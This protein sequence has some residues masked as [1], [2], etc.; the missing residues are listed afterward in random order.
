MWRESDVRPLVVVWAIVPRYSLLIDTYI[1]D[2]AERERL[3][4]A[5]ARVPAVRAKA[6]WA[7]RWIGSQVRVA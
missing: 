6:E 3:F 5:I 1:S 2:D 7:L 4:G